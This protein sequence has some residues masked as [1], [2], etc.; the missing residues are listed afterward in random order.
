M[1]TIQDF[2]KSSESCQNITSYW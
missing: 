1:Y 2:V